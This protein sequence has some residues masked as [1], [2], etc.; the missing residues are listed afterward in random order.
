VNITSGLPIKVQYALYLSLM[1]AFLVKQRI[2]MLFG[3]E[4]TPRTWREKMQS[5]FDMFSPLYQNRHEEEEA[6]AWFRQSGFTNVAIAYQEQYGFGARGDR[7][8]EEAAQLVAVGEK[9]PVAT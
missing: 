4:K 3:R 7:S 1:P 5:L 2:K 8:A 9:Q 6:L